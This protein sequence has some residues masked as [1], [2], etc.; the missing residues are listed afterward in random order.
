MSHDLIIA[1]VDTESII[2]TIL[3]VPMQASFIA[4]VKND[5]DFRVITLAIDAFHLVAGQRAVESIVVT[6]SVMVCLTEKHCA[7]GAKTDG[8]TTA[9]GTLTTLD[10]CKTVLSGEVDS[11]RR[12]RRLAET[13]NT[14][15]SL[16]FDPDDLPGYRIMLDSGDAEFYESFDDSDS[17]LI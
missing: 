7:R 14:S 1:T 10:V 11:E 6:A 4:K 3:C 5:T 15:V 12:R 16:R 17:L 13:E 8:I 9:D 2:S